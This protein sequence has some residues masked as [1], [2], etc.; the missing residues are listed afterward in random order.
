MSWPTKSGN[1][2]WLL[3]IKSFRKSR[4]GKELILMAFWRC[5]EKYRKWTETLSQLGKRVSGQFPC[6]QKAFQWNQ[7]CR[8]IIPLSNKGL[9]YL[10]IFQAKLNSYCKN[11]IPGK[12]LDLSYKT[13]NGEV[14]NKT[15][16]CPECECPKK[17]ISCEL[18]KII[19]SDFRNKNFSVQKI[20]LKNPAKVASLVCCTP[21]ATLF[22]YYLYQKLK[23]LRESRHEARVS[24]QLQ[25]IPYMMRHM[26]PSNIM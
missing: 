8:G 15:V 21:I 10:K 1:L 5:T 23:I 16:F 14:I 17:C 25:H 11:M 7:L 19:A 4:V 18:F 2:S 12:S 26:K 3:I 22:S 6:R 13:P 24:Q 9:I 20:T